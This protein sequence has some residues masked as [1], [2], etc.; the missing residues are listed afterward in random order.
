[1]GL[2]ER[3]FKAAMPAFLRAFFVAQA[4]LPVFPRSIPPMTR[5]ACVVE[6]VAS[7]AGPLIEHRQPCMRPVLEQSQRNMRPGQLVVTPAAIVGDVA[8]SASRAIERGV[9][10]VDIVPP[11]RCV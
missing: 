1:M 5:C 6:S 4:F 8:G 7:Q 10:A 11:A 3:P 2:V 9:A